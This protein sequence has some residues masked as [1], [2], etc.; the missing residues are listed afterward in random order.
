MSDP[1]PARAPSGPAA[2]PGSR[3]VA[4]GGRSAGGG[5]FAVRLAF[6][7]AL[8]VFAAA[9]FL[10]YRHA[11]DAAERAAL[12]RE[13]R[14][15][16]AGLAEWA[17]A[18]AAGE[19]AA[20]AALPGLRRRSLGVL[21]RLPPEAP[22]E[23]RA[24]WTG[25]VAALDRVRGEW[26]RIRSQRARVEDLRVEA[27]R[28][29]DRSRRLADLLAGG[30]GEGPQAALAVKALSV[31]PRAFG[32]ELRRAAFPDT[33]G[34]ERAAPLL[35]VWERAAEALV[36]DGVR[37]L[38]GAEAQLDLATLP[39]RVRS[40]V[41]PLAEA[42][43]A[44]RALAPARAA[45]ERLAAGGAAAARL[46][47]QIEA[48]AAPPPVFGVSNDAWRFGAGA[49]AF[50]ALLVLVRRRGGGRSPAGAAYAPPLTL[51]D[52]AASGERPAPAFSD[53]ALAEV[54]DAGEEVPREIV[55]QL[56]GIRDALDRIGEDAPGDR[57]GGE[58]AGQ[59]PA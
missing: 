25:V 59:R 1:S 55:E 56:E 46:A 37:R 50:A 41:E 27:A 11:A 28:L 35:A 36:E 45:F 8:A 14:A 22:R 3:P 42:R 51:G 47:P 32:T 21:V 30:A 43:A 33:M 24:A 38:A 18:A 31:A 54:R 19:G 17:R 7:A 5:A 40:L 44:A 12:V 58:D 52:A 39:E 15:L 34:L 2:V 10:H 20:E 53:E 49:A 48:A 9:S 6:L 57:I 29:T 26:R 4:A 13:Q 16:A 23:L